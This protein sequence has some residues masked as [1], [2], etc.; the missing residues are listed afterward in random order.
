MRIGLRWRTILL[1]AR[2]PATLALAVLFTV[3]RNVKAH[4]DASSIHESL[5]HSAAV[6]ESMLK[7]RSRAL[8]GGAQ[9]IARDPRFFSL[10]MLGQDQRDYRFL[11]TVR[12]MAQDFNHI[13]QTDLFEV[14]DRRGR[15]LAS[16]GS[17]SSSRGARDEMV[18][19]ALQGESVEGVLVENEIHFQVALTPVYADRRVVGVL[20]LGAQIGSALANELRTEMLCEVTFLTGEH[21]TGT[22]LGDTAETGA[23]IRTLRE[24]HLRDDAMLARVGVLQVRVQGTVYLTLVRHLPGADAETGQYY[25]I[26]R[27]FDPETSFLQIMRQDMI[28][29]AAVALI[30]ALLTGLAFSEQILRPIQRL[31]KGAQA[32]EEGNY[33]HPIEIHRSDEIGYLADRF[34]EMRRRERATLDSLEQA[35]RL[36]SQ[37]LSI[38]SHELRTPVSVLVGYRDLLAGGSLGPVTPQ[39]TEALETM[40]EQLARLAGMADEAARFARLRGERLTLDTQPWD[41][42]PIVDAAV[43]AARAAGSRRAVAIAMQCE[44]GL[45]KLEVDALALEQGIFQLITNG[46]RFTADGGQ[47][48]VRATRSGAE[49]VIEVRDTGVG[50]EPERLESLLTRG[51]ATNEVNHHRSTTSLEFNST[52]LGL[53]LGITRAVVE[54]HGGELKATSQPGVG[55][56]FVIT[57][58][59]RPAGEGRAAA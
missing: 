32:M 24:R 58:P 18:R 49:V 54:A 11:S 37:F 55:S 6:F 28:A 9:I 42:E 29:L 35:A 4:V 31:V 46:I 8:A 52:G 14:M 41:L 7:T 51:A 44:P 40:R 15:L 57:L 47:V 56:A 27:S 38:A 48:A 43:A 23:L 33:D 34:R 12:G 50:I 17:A 3:D 59:L 13:T 1:T 22:T 53:G 45:P 36:K 26:Q 16:V 19:R 2:T 39:Q 5:G 10:L 20:M 25:V 21:V 30:L